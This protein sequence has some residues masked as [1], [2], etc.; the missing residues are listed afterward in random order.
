MELE[1]TDEVIQ[2]HG[3]EQKP[4]G[5]WIYVAGESQ[6]SLAAKKKVKHIAQL[7]DIDLESALEYCN[8]LEL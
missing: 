5:G 8:S 6:L 2:S 3:W 1:G 4:D 7:L